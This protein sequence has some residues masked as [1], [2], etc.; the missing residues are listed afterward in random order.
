MRVLPLQCYPRSDLDSPPSLASPSQND[1]FEG[2][3]FPVPEAD[4]ILGPINDLR[5]KHFDFV[6]V[7]TTHHPLNYSGF[8][9]NNPVSPLSRLSPSLQD[10]TI[11]SRGW[12]GRV[13]LC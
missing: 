10:I 1:Y 6:F 11:G 9:S 5:A 8:A 3:S 7:C 12:D 4:G 13:R 2:G